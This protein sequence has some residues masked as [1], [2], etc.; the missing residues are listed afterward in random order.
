VELPFQLIPPLIFITLVSLMTGVVK[1]ADGNFDTETFFLVYVSLAFMNVMGAAW[2][3]VIACV[4]PNL[5]TALF[6]APASVVPLILFSGA[7]KSTV[8]FPWVVRWISYIDFITYVWEFIVFS[9]FKKKEFVLGPSVNDTVGQTYIVNERLHFAWP[10]AKDPDV[11]ICIYL[12]IAFAVL[13]N[14]LAALAL[15]RKLTKVAQ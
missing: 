7:F 4:A 15:R 9:V 8:D 13:Y 10:K 12:L 2:A 5:P 3:N 11:N 6:M 1:D 14:T